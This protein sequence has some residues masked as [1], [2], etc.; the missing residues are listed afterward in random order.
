MPKQAISLEGG[1]GG[2]PV[3]LSVETQGKVN[4]ALSKFIGEIPK[5]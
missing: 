1:E 2:E 5:K 4:E 3:R